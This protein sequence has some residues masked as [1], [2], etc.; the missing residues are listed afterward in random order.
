MIEEASDAIEQLSERDRRAQEY[1][2]ARRNRMRY[3]D[4]LLNELEMLN[5]ADQ[6]QTPSELGAAVDQLIEEAD[7]EEA[8]QPR[9]S[10]TIL[11]AMD[12]L[13]EIQDSLMFNQIEDE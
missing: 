1:K 4:R 8:E 5:L 2:Y 3:I 9:V 10:S 12:A 6:T 11:H 7:L 13:F